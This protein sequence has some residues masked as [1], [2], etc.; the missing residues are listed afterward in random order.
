MNSPW[1]PAGPLS[2]QRED[3]AHRTHLIW[4]QRPRV[5]LSLL[6]GEPK[7]PGHPSLNGFLVSAAG[8]LLALRGS[9][10]P[11]PPEPGGDFSSVLQTDLDHELP[12]P[13]AWLTP[14]A[15]DQLSPAWV[16]PVPLQ[17]GTQGPPLPGSLVLVVSAL[18]PVPCRGAL[19]SWPGSKLKAWAAF[20]AVT[21][22][23]PSPSCCLSL[24][25]ISVQGAPCPRSRP[26]LMASVAGGGE[27]TQIPCPEDPTG[28]SWLL[29]ADNAP[30][31]VSCWP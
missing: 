7:V 29:P 28:L 20:Q 6:R 13:L 5:A 23:L 30:S 10:H 18:G 21:G 14:A 4:C 9:H 22:R 3:L 19:G 12:G 2:A 25:P 26:Q 15:G 8:A 1:S 27:S 16:T 24:I 31:S 17:P 11:L